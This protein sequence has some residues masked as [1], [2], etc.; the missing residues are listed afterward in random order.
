MS[1]NL[2][3]NEIQVRKSTKSVNF[4]RNGFLSRLLF[5]PLNLTKE[6]AV[7]CHGGERQ[8]DGRNDLPDARLRN[9][10]RKVRTCEIA[11]ESA[12]SHEA[13]ARPVDEPGE[14]E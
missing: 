14:N 7:K 2:G 5:T 13:C 11:H 1:N 12:H 4:W 8:A 10:L 3:V 6:L 9:A